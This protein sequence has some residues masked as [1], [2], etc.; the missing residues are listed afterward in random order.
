M[1]HYVLI[2]CVSVLSLVLIWGALSVALAKKK[3]VKIGIGH[4]IGIVIFSFYLIIVFD[5][6]GIPNITYIKEIDLAH[7]NLIPFADYFRRP[8][9]YIQN[10]L[11]F[12]PM[13]FMLP[14]LWVRNQRFFKVFFF[15]IGITLFI[16]LSQFFTYR[17]PD[18]DDLMMNALGGVT[19]Y[20]LYRITNLFLHKLYN[21]MALDAHTRAAGFILRHE[22]ILVIA[23]VVTGLFFIKPYLSLLIAGVLF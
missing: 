21:L 13:G 2:D 22:S 11:L 19:G 23:L 4:V 10:V 3:R 16:E 12:I 7:Y 5:V 15:S 17:A 20:V 18:I 14:M 8:T 1:L 9:G 6:V